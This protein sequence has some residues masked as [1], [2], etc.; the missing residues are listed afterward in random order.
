M[1]WKVVQ[2][3]WRQVFLQWL[4]RAHRMKARWKTSMKRQ[5]RPSMY[6]WPREASWQVLAKPIMDFQEGQSY[7]EVRQ[8]CRIFL[9]IDNEN[10]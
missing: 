10:A 2:P 5:L 7:G 9:V 4:P 1:V 3:N 8:L 6:G